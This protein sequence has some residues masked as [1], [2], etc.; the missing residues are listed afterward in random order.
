MGQCSRMALPLFLPVAPDTVALERLEAGG[1]TLLASVMVHQSR[2]GLN[3]TVQVEFFLSDTAPRP[4]SID[5]GLILAC[6]ENCCSSNSSSIDPQVTAL[7][8]FKII[9]ASGEPVRV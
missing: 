5:S 6:K 8:Y 1:C 9:F 4:F 3:L 2:A 7:K